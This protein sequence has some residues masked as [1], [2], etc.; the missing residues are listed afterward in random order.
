[1]A[2]ALKPESDSEKT[3]I[4]MICL[5]VA[6]EDLGLLVRPENDFQCKAMGDGHWSLA[7][8]LQTG[9]KASQYPSTIFFKEFS[10]RT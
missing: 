4:A 8:G 7:I 10:E 2:E 9:Q 6:Q 3:E 5:D 1:M